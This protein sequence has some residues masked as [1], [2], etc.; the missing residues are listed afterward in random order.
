[1]FNEVKT[2]LSSIDN[3]QSGQ[4]VQQAA[5][6]HVEKMGEAQVQQHVQ[7]AA[8]NASQS[9]D[10]GAADILRSVLSASQSGSIK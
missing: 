1:M 2:L 3:A 7:M 4:A 8:N 10:N 5:G 9:G 6:D